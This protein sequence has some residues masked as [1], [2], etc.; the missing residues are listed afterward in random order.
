MSEQNIFISERAAL[1]RVNRAIA[2][3]GRAMKV[4]RHDSRWFS[5]L[6][7]YYVVNKTTHV[8][9]DSHADLNWWARELGVLKLFEE[10]VARG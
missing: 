10:I 7:R 9:S 5:D 3:A 2:H 6:G 1:Q 4:C 8:V